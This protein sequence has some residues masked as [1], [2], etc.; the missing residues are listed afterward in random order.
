MFD[1]IKYV[2][3]NEIHNSILFMLFLVAD[4]NKRDR[5]FPIKLRH[6]TSLQNRSTRHEK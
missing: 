2:F 4:A 1:E 5:I 6:S 3:Q